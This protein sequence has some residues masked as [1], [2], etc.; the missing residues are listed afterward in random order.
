MSN[1]NEI[2]IVL[3]VDSAT[4]RAAIKSFGDQVDRSSRQ[5][6][7]S[8]E[9]MATTMRSSETQAKTM[10]GAW[11]MAGELLPIAGVTL[12]IAGMTKLAGATLAT[13]DR[14]KLLNGQLKLVTASEE[15]LIAVR[16]K[17]YTLAD[18]NRQGDEATI[19]L[20]ARLSRATQEL[21][22]S[23][24]DRLR[25]TD[26]VGKSMIISSASTA[27]AEAAMIQL[28][29][30]MASGVLRG[31][32]L[33][34]IMEQAPRLAQ[35]IAQGLGVTI[36]ELRAMGKEGELTA[37]K[38]TA[39]I[40]KSGAAIDSEAAKMSTTIGQAALKIKNS[41]GRVVESF[42][43]ATD[44]SGILAG[45]LEDIAQGIN[46]LA[47]NEQ[48]DG[49]SKKMVVGLSGVGDVLHGISVATQSI[50]GSMVVAGVSAVNLA[51]SAYKVARGDL[52][53]A[54]A[55]IEEARGVV[56]SYRE[57]MDNLWSAKTPFQNLADDYYGPKNEKAES[58]SKTKKNQQEQ[59]DFKK[60][61]TLANQ[62]QKED[63]QR[64]AEKLRLFEEYASQHQ[65]AEEEAAAAAS[66][67]WSDN[68][69]MLAQLTAETMPEH[70][71]AVARIEER[72]ELLNYA[73]SKMAI[74]AD[75]AAKLRQGLAEKQGIDLASADTEINSFVGKHEEAASQ[76]PTLWDHA[77]EEMSDSFAD[78]F[79]RGEDGLAGF[80]DAWQQSVGQMVATYIFGQR[81]M[82]ASQSSSLGANLGIAGSM[83]GTSGGGYAGYASAGMGI[84]NELMNPGATM[85]GYGSLQSSLGSLAGSMGL[86]TTGGG[87]ASAAMLAE[88]FGA[89]AP[90]VV[91]S[92][93]PA[94][95][96]AGLSGIGTFAMGL[97][98]GKNIG[99]AATSGAG[100]A[101]GAYIGTQLLP[102]IGTVVGS[103]LGSMLGDTLGNSLFGGDDPWV[104]QRYT[105]IGYTQ[106]Q[107]FN[108]LEDDRFAALFTAA[109]ETITAYVAS[110]PE[111]LQ[112]QVLA[113]FATSWDRKD[114]NSGKEGD[115]QE[116]GTELANW[117]TTS[118]DEGMTAAIKTAL[119]ATLTES[120]YSKDPS[121]LSAADPFELARILDREAWAVTGQDQQAGFYNYAPEKLYSL[122]D[123]GD[124]AG[125][126]QFAGQ[127]AQAMDQLLNTIDPQRS[128]SASYALLTMAQQFGAVRQNAE[129]LG[130]SLELIDRA[131]TAA[132]DA[133]VDSLLA[134]MTDI[135]ESHG[136]DQWQQGWDAIQEQYDGW[137]QIGEDLAADDP[138]FDLAGHLADA[139]LAAEELG[140]DLIDRFI[141]PVRD[142]VEDTIFTLSMEGMTP[143]ATLAT[144][145]ERA[146]SLA[147]EAQGQTGE[148]LATTA[149]EINDLAQPIIDAAHEAY[150]SGGAF[151][152]HKTW[153]LGLI[154]GVDSRLENSSTGLG[155]ETSQPQ[156]LQ[157][158]SG[159][160]S[161][162]ITEA[163]IRAIV[164]EVTATSQP[165]TIKVM[166]VD[167]KVITEQTL[168]ELSRRSLEGEVVVFAQGVAGL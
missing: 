103:V 34:S 106:G 71:Q 21:N 108:V 111:E 27:S 144:L 89:G 13:A 55:D 160:A 105:G 69:D 91:S 52:A 60:H 104:R 58:T 40:M 31:E 16:G 79:A 159:S 101:A 127:Y 138:L 100:S 39:A 143:Q 94:S 152:D 9:R 135:L 78:F 33:N 11:K 150:A 139:S 132:K 18:N 131:G 85:A 141:R 2:G 22:I 12:S 29:Q 42:D 142:A 66:K 24:A 133:L 157:R 75:Q 53:G 51:T 114:W 96:A 19:N 88:N 137:V 123:S 164:T 23:Q 20:F 155:V 74:T 166:T 61:Q 95:F 3:T 80:A 15:E 67:A 145:E 147:V 1:Q 4:G 72:Y 146:Y 92:L 154:S 153:L 120:Y 148:E 44:S 93:S 45:G 119:L 63:K 129:A 115:W 70:E 76:V 82:S 10:G 140:Q 7:Q 107:G 162:G 136:Q 149:K 8:L 84:I 77:T 17:L 124:V 26:L 81:Q 118:I 130:I 109:D 38:V 126:Y 99:Q 50:S 43:E 90:N 156:G 49:W 168:T 57:E 121:Q 116:V 59:E 46:D 5:G 14:Y 167:G 128:A 112:A 165:I 28:S 161:Q 102:G 73:I 41:T 83:L 110:F 113:A 151:S 47:K 158:S 37:E 6:A 36:G 62:E 98:Q 163:Q 86:G 134:P 32:E 117:L 122:A 125:A 30:A 97:A 87:T 65:K 25:L 64:L 56:A 48:L 54:R 35:A 68:L